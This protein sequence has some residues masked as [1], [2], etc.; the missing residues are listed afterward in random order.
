MAYIS[1]NPNPNGLR[2]GDCTVRAIS[3]ALDK[4]WH[5][6]YIGLALK[7]LEMGDMPSSNQVWGQYLKDN[8]F[9]RI[10]LPDTCPD[11]YT[12]ADFC[13]DHPHGLYVVGTGNHVACI[14]DGSVYDTWDSSG[15]QA[16][17]YWKKEDA[18]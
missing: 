1:V 12:I 5:E 15:E 2:V 4:E 13:K 8:G 7:G 16:L 11:C 6:V 17:I 18:E 14:S 10:S 3:T 9:K